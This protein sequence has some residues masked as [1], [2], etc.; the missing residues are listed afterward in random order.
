MKYIS[1]SDICRDVKHFV[2]QIFKC[3]ETSEQEFEEEN[4]PGSYTYC[5]VESRADG[6]FL[7]GS[8]EL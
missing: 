6:M 8:F 5:V 4:L 2:D 3:I 7:F 1:I